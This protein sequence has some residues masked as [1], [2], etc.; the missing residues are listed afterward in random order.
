M[1]MKDEINAPLLLTIGAVSVL[2]LVISA[3]AVDGWY[4]S[5]EADEISAKWDQSPNNWLIDLRKGQQENLERA[6]RLMPTQLRK[7]HVS[8]EDA[9]KVVAKNEGNLK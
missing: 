4:K 2:L 9:M 3:V 1:A 6:Y 8:I 7:Y 5:F